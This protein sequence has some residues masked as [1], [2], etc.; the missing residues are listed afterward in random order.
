MDIVFHPG[1]N[2]SDPYVEFYPYTPSASA[3]Y[4]FTALFGL[5]TIAHIVAAIILRA[6]YFVPLILGGICKPLSPPPPTLLALPHPYLIANH[7]PPRRSIRLLRP[8]LVTPFPHRYPAL[9]SAGDAYPVCAAIDLR[10]G[11]YASR[12]GSYGVRSG[13]CEPHAAEDDDNI[14]RAE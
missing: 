3:G 6:G 10:D 1:T 9:G 8:R 13:A 14:V 11:V 12:A 5:V 4:A 7:P 2:G